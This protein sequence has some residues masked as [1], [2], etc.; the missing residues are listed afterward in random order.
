MGGLHDDLVESALSGLQDYHRDAFLLPEDIRRRL[1]AL[2]QSPRDA[3]PI[4]M[5]SSFRS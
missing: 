1:Q 2:T 5:P 4:D 3:A